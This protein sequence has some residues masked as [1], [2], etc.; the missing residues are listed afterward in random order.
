MYAFPD[1]STATPVAVSLLVPP[2]Y[3]AALLAVL[4]RSSLATNPS[5]GAVLPAPP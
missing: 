2:K 3:T 1:E 4:E 5:V